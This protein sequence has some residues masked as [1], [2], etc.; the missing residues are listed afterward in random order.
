MPYGFCSKSPSKLNNEYRCIYIR[1]GVDR[2]RALLIFLTRLWN[3]SKPEGLLFVPLEAC[4]KYSAR[5]KGSQNEYIYT[6]I[7]SLNKN[8]LLTP[9]PS[10]NSISKEDIYPLIL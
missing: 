9:E 1:F 7:H 10:I 3:K 2:L 5:R 6:E 8:G 4:K